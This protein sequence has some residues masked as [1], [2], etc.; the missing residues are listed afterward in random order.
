M[1]STHTETRA[2]LATRFARSTRVLRGDAPLTED[3]MRSAAPSV[4][5]ETVEASGR[6][7]RILL[8]VDGSSVSDRA[9]QRLIAMR[10]DLADPAE[11]TLHLLNVQR[12]VSGDVSSFV[13]SQSLDE[14]YQ[15][16]GEKALASARALLD[17]AGVP[18]EAQQR[19]GPPGETIANQAR[20]NRIDLI[21]MGTKGA[22]AAAALMGSVAQG[23]LEHTDTPVM[24]VK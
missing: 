14:Y 5:A 18:Y 19:V 16:L 7:R 15:E 22:G 2:H 6:L 23:T 9:T 1:Y 4:P 11:L 17:A 20:S 21:V 8:A 3:Q 24:L 13:A 10:Q 12:P